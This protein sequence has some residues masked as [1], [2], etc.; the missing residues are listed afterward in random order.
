MLIIATPPSYP[1]AAG[2]RSLVVGRGA[3]AVV[4][5]RFIRIVA[6]TSDGFVIL[7]LT[8]SAPINRFGVVFPESFLASPA[9]SLVLSIPVVLSTSTPP[10]PSPRAFPLVRGRLVV[11]RKQRILL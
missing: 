9:P 10:A 6:Y 7:N 3:P 8:E 11:R 1:S 2:F 4:A 5:A